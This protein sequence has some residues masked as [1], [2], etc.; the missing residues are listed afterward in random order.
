MD[1]NDVL[2]PSRQVRARYHVSDMC[3]WRWLRNPQLDFPQPIRINGRRFWRLS[4]LQVWER[5][6]ASSQ[7]EV[8]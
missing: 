7:Q 5:R 1:L 2:L 6:R 8:R 4:A 3:L